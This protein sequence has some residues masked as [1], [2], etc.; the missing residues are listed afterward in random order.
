M[1]RFCSMGG[2]SRLHC[3]FFPFFFCSWSGTLCRSCSGVRGSSEQLSS[4][5]TDLASQAGFPERGESNLGISRT[6]VSG[7]QGRAL[8]LGSAPTSASPGCG[9]KVPWMQVC[10]APD[11]GSLLGTKLP[12]FPASHPGPASA[13]GSRSCWPVPATGS[14]Q[15]T[16]RSC[17]TRRQLRETVQ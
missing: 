13:A 10:A 1:S 15:W 9:L 4:V 3:S 8:C 17:P 12:H 2:L 6:R 14:W 16:R 7:E 11:R 5:F